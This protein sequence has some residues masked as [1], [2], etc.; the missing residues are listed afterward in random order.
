MLIIDHR[1]TTTAPSPT[2]VRSRGAADLGV[3][4]ALAQPAAAK[5]TGIGASIASQASPGFSAIALA[6]RIAPSGPWSMTASER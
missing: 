3:D 6:P 5:N 1:T 4:V 2:R